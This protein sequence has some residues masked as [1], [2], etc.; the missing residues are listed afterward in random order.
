MT[1]SVVIE[2]NT[3]I[4]LTDPTWLP[5]E[6]EEIKEY[7]QTIRNGKS[8][9]IILTHSDF[10]H[11]LGVGAFPDA[12]VIA[13][14]EFMNHPEKNK[15]IEQ[16]TAFDTRYYLKR[17]YKLTYPRADILVK[18]DQQEI[19]IDET[20]LTF[21]KAPGHTSD[22]LFTVI[23]PLGI[24]LAGDY[25]SDVEFPF[26]FSGYSDYVNTMK[27]AKAILNNHHI[28]T[29]VP[30]HGHTTERKAEMEKRVNDSLAYLEQLATN[31]EVLEQ[32]LEKQYPFFDGMKSN[33]TQ[34]KTMALQE[35]K[36][37]K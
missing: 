33:H 15:I 12:A 10:D 32:R 2:T 8:L 6:V 30:G 4:I 29:L 14:E 1:T 37:G 20:I 13:T 11:I 24:L 19:R 18:H 17:D 36:K 22:G 21:Y 31:D 23:E 26:I 7:V 3:A 35:L 34:N 28:S 5:N 25:L 9:Y 16:I 27:K